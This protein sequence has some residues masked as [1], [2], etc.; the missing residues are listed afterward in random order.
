MH[1][2]HASLARKHTGRG[3]PQDAT[4]LLDILWAHA[5]EADH[6]EHAR[7]MAH[8][9]RVDVLLFFRQTH[10]DQPDHQAADL[11]CR[12]H[13]ASPL[14]QAKYQPPEPLAPHHQPCIGD[15]P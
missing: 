7:G 4:E 1:L 15:T 8:P 14:L 12:C 6:L 13:Q 5:T 2:V 9:D 11:L 3:D 10:A